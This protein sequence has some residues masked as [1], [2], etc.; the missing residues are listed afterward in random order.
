MFPNFVPESFPTRPTTI[1]I[2]PL[3]DP[4]IAGLVASINDKF[5]KEGIKIV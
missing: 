3:A 2:F 5:D 1:C 4:S